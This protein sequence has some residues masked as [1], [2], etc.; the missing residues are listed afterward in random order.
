MIS[1]TAAE[2]QSSAS[3]P[4]AAFVAACALVFTVASFWW[5]NARQGDLKV[6]EPHSFA[7]AVTSKIA[8]IRFP[9]VLYN[10]GAKP[11]V[12]LDLRLR[13]LDEPGSALVLPWTSTR[14]RLRPEEADDFR[15]PACFA[16]TG[17]TAEQLFIEFGA[18]FPAFVPEARDYKV[19]VEAKLGYRKLRH[20]TLGRRG[21]WQALVVFPLRV[22]HIAHPS[23][24]IAYSN[25]PHDMTEDDRREAEVA[26]SD[27]RAKFKGGAAARRAPE[28]EAE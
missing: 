5:I 11:I 13:F 1:L 7:A 18:P 12:V 22:G 19:V 8:R 28:P 20:R 6:W 10:T 4:L 21:D 9:L 16:V 27:L 25:S 24:Y 26:L 2:Q 15:L 3:L 14:D 23:S 17:R